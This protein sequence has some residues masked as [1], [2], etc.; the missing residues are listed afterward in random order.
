MAKKF[1]LKVSVFKRTVEP[2]EE[3]F[4]KLHHGGGFDLMKLDVNQKSD[5]FD[6]QEVSTAYQLLSVSLCTTSLACSPPCR[7][8]EAA[9]PLATQILPDLLPQHLPQLGQVCFSY[10]T[11][12]TSSSCRTPVTKVTGS[13]GERPVWVLVD[14]SS[15][16]SLIPPIHHH[17]SRLPALLASGSSMSFRSNHLSWSIHNS[18]RPN[19]HNKSLVNIHGWFFFSDRT[20]SETGC[21]IRRIQS[22]R[23]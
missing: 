12:G 10:V 3:H 23:P 20:L 17:L 21:V 7:L 18:L 9:R 13:A 2:W 22:N 16:L 15:S 6:T 8:G 1:P 11:K 14:L 4:P 19:S 5:S